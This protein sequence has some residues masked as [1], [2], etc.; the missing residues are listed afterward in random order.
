MRVSMSGVMAMQLSGIRIQEKVVQWGISMEQEE[1]E[2]SDI[3]G[4]IYP[5]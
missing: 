3:M 5:P 4:V 1:K 2:N